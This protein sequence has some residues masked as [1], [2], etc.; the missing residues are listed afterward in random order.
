[1]GLE[2]TTSSVTGW[3]SN[4]LNYRTKCGGHNRARTYDPLLVRQMLSQLSYAPTFFITEN[5][6]TK[7]S[8]IGYFSTI[9]CKSQELYMRLFAIRLNYHGKN[10]LKLCFSLNFKVFGLGLFWAKQNAGCSLHHSFCGQR[11]ATGHSLHLGFRASQ[12]SLP[13]NTRQ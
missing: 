10:S 9:I 11:C 6:F 7:I 13:W 1:M 3:H 8:N 4:Q 2:P 5:L 12:Y